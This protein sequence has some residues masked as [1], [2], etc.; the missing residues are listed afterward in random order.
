MLAGSA[1]TA[2]VRSL[3][4][5]AQHHGTTSQPGGKTIASLQGLQR[6]AWLRG[7]QSGSLHEVDINVRSQDGI[8]LP[9]QRDVTHSAQRSATLAG[10]AVKG[11]PAPMG[12][13]HGGPVFFRCEGYLA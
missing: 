11:D 4:A 8:T 2:P 9:A 7:R 3:H 6:E 12:I 10:E 5:S 1:L 13:L